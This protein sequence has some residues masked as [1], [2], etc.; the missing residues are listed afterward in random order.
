MNVLF[1]TKALWKRKPCS[2]T[3]NQFMKMSGTCVKYVTTNSKDWII[4]NNTQKSNSHLRRHYNASHEVKRYPCTQCNYKVSDLSALKKHIKSVH[5][6]VKHECDICG[7]KASSRSNLNTHIK[8]KHNE[9]K[10]YLCDKC[11]ME[12]MSRTSLRRHK[13]FEHDAITYNCELCTYKTRLKER[14]K[15]HQAVHEK[16][17]FLDSK[18]NT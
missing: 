5:E 9:G 1:V 16:W 14:L 6:G 15:E 13:E 18:I 11:N 3:L 10:S 2:Y 8:I 7:L 4:W 12:C 17:H